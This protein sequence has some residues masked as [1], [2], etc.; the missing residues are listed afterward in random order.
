MNAVL[1]KETFLPPEG[2]TK[3]GLKAH[4]IIVSY[5][6]KRGLLSSGYGRDGRVFELPQ[7]DNEILRITYD[8]GA[9]GEAFEY[10]GGSFFLIDGMIE[11]LRR[12]GFWSEPINNWSSAIRLLED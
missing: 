9:H 12:G 10:S 1:E 11:A 4:K 3:V 6:K 5:L 2:L 7:D 8:G